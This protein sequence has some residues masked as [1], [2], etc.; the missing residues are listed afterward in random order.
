MDYAPS[1]VSFL[2]SRD[3]FRVLEVESPSLLIES[4]IGL[5]YCFL[6]SN[7]LG[8][9]AMLNSNSVLLFP[10]SSSVSTT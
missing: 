4:C 1:L 9:V 7:P 8:A 2:G 10:S 5:D 6:C 3:S